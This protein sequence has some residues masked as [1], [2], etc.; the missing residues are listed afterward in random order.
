MTTEGLRGMIAPVHARRFELWI[1]FWLAVLGW[2]VWAGVQCLTDGLHL[3]NMD[4]RFVFAMWIFLDLT[5]IALGAGAFFTGFL[6]FI[7][8]REEVRDIIN[9]AVVLGFI[10]Y[11]SAIAVLMVDVGQPIRAWFTFWHPNVHSMLAEVTFCITCYL[12]VL[13]LEYL[14]LVLRNKKLAKVPELSSLG[15]Q[16]HR[17]VVVLA[18]VGAFLS[19]FHQGS[20]GGLY[21][22][23]NGRP[24]AFRE[25][26][27]IWPATFFLFI[28]SAIAAG[29]S[30]LMLV[31]SLASKLSGRRLV[32]DSTF[33]FLGKLSGRLLAL[34]VCLKTIDT[35]F[36]INET[37]PSAGFTAFGFYSE[38]S[39][40]GTWILMT[41]L[42]V[43]GAVPAVLLSMRRTRRRRPVL[44]ISAALCCAGIGLNRFV[45]TIQTLAVPTTPFE[46][47]QMYVPNVQ[48]VAVTMGVV[49]YGVLVFSLSVRFL[50]IFPAR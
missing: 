2:G 33:D 29:P 36:W 38:A 40:A 44:L 28:L 37:A 34:Y 10:C 31:T 7:L 41:E 8:K 12:M 43:L 3:T 27:A 13:A 45:Q 24:F 4:N 39:I 6:L 15:H 49:A 14:P 48:E 1:L 22:V 26:F 42:I 35:L 30:F 11:S 21:G 5:V 17:L 19:F 23:L 18:G 47:F 25:G 46:G 32:A 20:L 9:A 50:P 16:V